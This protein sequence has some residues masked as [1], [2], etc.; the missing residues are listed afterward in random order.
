MSLLSTEIDEV[1]A[2]AWPLPRESRQAF[3]AAVENALAAHPVR[4]AGL[5]HRVAVQ[6]Q[7]QFFTPP[8]PEPGPQHFHRRKHALGA[9]LHHG[10]ER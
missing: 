7:R 3:V 1:Q 2:L 9:P 8:D 10:R 5:A 6:L 4:G